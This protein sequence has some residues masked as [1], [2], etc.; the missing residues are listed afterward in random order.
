M[1]DHD[2]LTAR[3]IAWATTHDEIRAAIQVGSGA[4]SDHPADEWADM[5]IMMFST[6]PEAFAAD[7]RWLEELGEVWAAMPS[8]TA[9]ND[10]EW[11]VAFEDGIFVDFVSL[12]DS[13]LKQFQDAHAL[14]EIYQR[15]SRLLV[16]RDN[17]LPPIMPSSFK[18]P[19]YTPPTAA[20]FERGLNS[21]WYGCMYIARQLRRGDV[22]RVKLMESNFLADLTGFIEV[23]THATRGWEIDTWH[24]GRFMQ[25]WADPAVLEA[26]Q[27][28]HADG[29]IMNCWNALI[30]RMNLVRRIARE[31]AQSMDFSYPELLDER[32]TGVCKQTLC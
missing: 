3:F 15:G 12:P 24:M 4:R 25:E 2:E 6:T 10:P 14:P 7:G 21:F 20:E 26:L 31:I 13:M 28:I 17:V 8:R 30:V 22:W 27:N 5:D 32:A 23:H 29:D 19:T 18:S 11:L 16:D 1:L 9:G